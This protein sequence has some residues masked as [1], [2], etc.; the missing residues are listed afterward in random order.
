MK[1]L[2]EGVN[3]ADMQPLMCGFALPYSVRITP[4]QQM[5]DVG[6]CVDPARLDV[7]FDPGWLEVHF[8]PGWVR[9]MFG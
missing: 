1:A 7:C 4:V 6:V 5:A 3:H 2:N 8:S 9:N